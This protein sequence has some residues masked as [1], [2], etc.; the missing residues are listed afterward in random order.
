MTWALVLTSGAGMSLSGPMSTSSSVKKRRLS[1]Q[2]ALRQLLG[3]D[4][5]AALAAAI[6]DAH[7]GAL[8]GHP[9][10][11]GL[12]LVEG[13]VLVVADA[14]LGWASAEVVLDA[15]A[16]EHAHRTVVHLHREVDVQLALGLRSTWRRPGSRLRRSAARSNCPAPRARC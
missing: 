5:D 15:I 10:R 14:A 1:F 2:L 11:E 7:D 16:R 13:D 6:G 9:H 4:D 12:D 3:V 8:P